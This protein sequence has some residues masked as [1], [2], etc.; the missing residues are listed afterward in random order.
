MSESNH[1]VNKEVDELEDGMSAEE[2]INTGS[3]LTYKYVDLLSVKRQQICTYKEMID[4]YSIQCLIQS[5]Q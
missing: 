1:M 5:I 3:G 4:V 2:M